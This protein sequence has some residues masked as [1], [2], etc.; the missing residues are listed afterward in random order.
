MPAAVAEGLS[1]VDWEVCV[2]EEA[3]HLKGDD[4]L[5]IPLD[6]GH[7]VKAK[8]G[9][10][11]SAKDNLKQCMAT[12]RLFNAFCATLEPLYFINCRR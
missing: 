1:E 9:L 6:Q 8:K 10:I 5:E 12:L 7:P 11:L 2:G 4:E 3:G